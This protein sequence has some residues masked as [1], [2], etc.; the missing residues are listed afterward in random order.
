MADW[1][2]NEWPLLLAGA[3]ACLLWLGV[4]AWPRPYIADEAGLEDEAAATTPRRGSRWVERGFEHQRD[5]W[6]LNNVPVWTVKQVD[7]I[8]VQLRSQT[9]LW[10][11]VRMSKL[12]GS[13]VLAR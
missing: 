3:L 4:R 8:W 7:G 12:L 13:Y 6:G 10:R 2:H 11:A 9:G 5:P 1:I